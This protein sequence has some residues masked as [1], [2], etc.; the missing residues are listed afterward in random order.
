MFVSLSLDWGLK[1]FLHG[2]F[3][4]KFW[5]GK[6]E[7]DFDI[8]Q[9]YTDSTTNEIIE[10]LGWIITIWAG[11]IAAKHWLKVKSWKIESELSF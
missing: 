8:E 10:I 6:S 11:T 2:L 4:L 5:S 3:F 1:G 9:L 7:D